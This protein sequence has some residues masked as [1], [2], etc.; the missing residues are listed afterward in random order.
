M[1]VKILP[2]NIIRYFIF[3]VVVDHSFQVGR[4]EKSYDRSRTGS[5]AI[6]DPETNSAR[7]VDASGLTMLV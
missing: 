5:E 3:V 7:C 6:T 2:M 1:I 4:V